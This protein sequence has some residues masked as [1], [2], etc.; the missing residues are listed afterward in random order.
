MTV[1]PSE[2]VVDPEP[3]VEEASSPKGSPWF[4]PVRAVILTLALMFLA[5]VVGYRIA[6]LDQPGEGSADV[7]FLQDMIVHHEQAVAMAFATADVA[8]DSVVRAFAKEMMAVQ[9]YEIG[10]MEAWLGRWGFERDSGRPTAMEWAGRGHDKRSMPG[11][12]SKEELDGLYA[13][14]G[15][16]VDDRF[17]RLMIA[18]HAGAI[19]MAEAVLER[20]EDEKVLDL[21]RRI[22]RNQRSEIQEM[23]V[24]RRRLGLPPAPVEGV[25]MG[26]ETSGTGPSSTSTTHH[27]G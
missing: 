25:P 1:P 5:G 15:I 23:Q 17:L 20:G 18:H 2:A 4:T 21:A 27:G 7:G 12:A 22:I 3:D 8:T 24:A 10:L 26:Q 14:K 19:P 16:E 6:D 13:A 9:Q 11:M